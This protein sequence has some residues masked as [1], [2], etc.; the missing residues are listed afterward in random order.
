MPTN[1][2]IQ[3]LRASTLETLSIIKDLPTLPERFMRIQQVLDDPDSTIA[4]LIKVIETDQATAT[5]ILK[6][7][8]SSYYNPLGHQVSSL[9]FAI[10]RLG[11]K[12]TADIALSMSLF[13]GFAMPA[14]FAVIQKFWSHAFATGQLARYLAQ[15]SPHQNF[16]HDVIFTAGLLQ[17]IGR[18]VIGMRI[19]IAYFESELGQNTGQTLLDQ[20]IITY[21]VTHEEVGE[22]TLKLWG[23]PDAIV[24]VAANHH[25]PKDS[26]KNAMLCHIADEIAHLHFNDC[27]TIEQVQMKM[28]DPE[29]M[30]MIDEVYLNIPPEAE[31]SIITD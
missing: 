1:T 26:N 4:D 22:I 15:M 18:V 28:Q 25:Q 14:S 7:A 31:S 5:T 13:Y 20:E 23:L 17:D 11:R 9:A 12:E 8:N 19:D 2:N 24:S 21:G 27:T 30:Q 6:I 3:T 29:F 10:S 16:D